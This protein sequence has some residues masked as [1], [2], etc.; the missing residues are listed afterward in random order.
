MTSGNK[1]AAFKTL[2]CKLNYSETSTMARGVCQ[3]GFR[4]V[5]FS[6][7]ADLYVINTCCVT[8]EAERKCRKE[9]RR[10]LRRSP[11]AFVAVTGCYAQVG[12]KDIAA[13]PGVDLVLGN[14]DKFDLVD[15]LDSL[16]KKHAQIH[17]CEAE[18]IDLFLPS[19][20]LTGR[21]RSFLKIQ[22]GC[23]Y[24][25]SYCT[26]PLA[27][28]VSRS[29]S[30]DN[31]V[32]PVR[33][34]AR[35]D[36]REIVLT[37][38]NVGDFGRHTGESFLELIQQLDTIE[39]V[40]RFRISSIEPNLLTDS[41]ISFVAQSRRFVPHFHIPLQSGS[42]KIL[43]LMKRRYSKQLYE[44]RIQMVKTL[45]PDCCIG[46][47]VV[48]GFPGEELEDFDETVEFI[49]EVDISYLHV[50]TYSERGNTSALEIDPVVV[51]EERAM[52]SRQLRSLSREKRKR[53][54]DHFIGETVSVLF[55][56]YQD[57]VLSGMTGNYIRVAAAGPEVLAGKI[58]D[59]RLFSNC[60]G[61]MR[62]ELLN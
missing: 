26:I 12:P 41:I 31:L 50:F 15:H 2:G 22:D 1:K 36:V 17:S 55:E 57:G 47:D 32:Q 33:E 34:I 38:V 53:Y 23:D 59:V 18:E 10:A 39:S 6:E 7:R 49:S 46:A 52:R 43:G 25:C 56:S 9:I 27:R 61:L 3:Y 24:N 37:G 54:H 35:A 45:I 21:T 29:D 28:G 62:G 19:Y 8:R 13:I 20:S 30:I 11:N 60:G 44:D 51:P 14:R 42:D 16:Q 5:D 58:G 40:D 4:Q 48:V